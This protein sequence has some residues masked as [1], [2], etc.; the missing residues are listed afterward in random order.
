MVASVISEL[1]R[2]PVHA[3]DQIALRLHQLV[4]AFA[5][6]VVDGR[7]KEV[8]LAQGDGEA[9]MDGFLGLMAVVEPVTVEFWDVSQGL[10]PLSTR[11]R[12]ARRPLLD[13]QS[14]VLGL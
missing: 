2:R 10:L 1:R 5:I 14:L 6:H 8:A 3:R 4:Q 12:R 9:D 11:A 7:R 13:R